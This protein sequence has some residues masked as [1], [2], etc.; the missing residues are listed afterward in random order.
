MVRLLNKIENAN[1][2]FI[3]SDNGGGIDE[4]SLNHIFSPGFS[5]KINY[6]TGEINRAL[7]CQ[8]FKIL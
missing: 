6:N 3:I 4:E 5:T 2:I 8:L 7:D 1:H